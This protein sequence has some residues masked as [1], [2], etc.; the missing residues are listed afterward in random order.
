MSSGEHSDL[1]RRYFERRSSLSGGIVYAAPSPDEEGETVV[2]KTSPVEKGAGEGFSRD[3]R[4]AHQAG[5]FSEG[6]SEG[7]DCSR[8][9]LEELAGAVAG[10]TLCQLSDTRTNTVFADGNPSARIVFIGE[11]PGRDED[12]QGVPFVGRA[13]KLLDKILASVG[14]SRGD[15]YIMNILK[16]RP[17]GNRD[18][19]EEE[20]AACERYLTRQIELVSPLVIC[21]LG[22]VAAQNLLGTKASLKMLREGVHRYNGIRVV[23]TY[24]PAALL[25]NP[26]F[27]RTV[28]ED[29]KMLRGLY[30]ELIDEAS[31]GK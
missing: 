4:R 24:H 29:M 16:C 13:G 21:A 15:V 27:K 12:L 26:N 3:T 6:P 5:L 31:G 2:I 22:R 8:M 19:G 14:F 28:W 25:R 10:C 17:P 11:A 30:D 9:D 20:V 23:V 7:V 18:P 1:L